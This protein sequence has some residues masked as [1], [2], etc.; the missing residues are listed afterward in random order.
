MSGS[1]T[2]SSMSAPVVP[3]GS[4]PSALP[5]YGIPPPGFIPPTPGIPPPFGV[6]MPS[7][8]PPSVFGVPPF[9][10]SAVPPSGFF[11]QTMPAQ[12]SIENEN[13]RTWTEHKSPDG[14]TYYYNNLTKQ[15]LWDKPDELK[16]A[17][18]IMLSQCPWKEYKTEDGK[19]YYHNVSTKESSWTIPPELGELKSKIATEE[20]NKTTIANGQTGTD[21][22]SSTVQISTAAM[23]VSQSVVTDSL[24]TPTR[25]PISALDQAMAATLAAITV[26]SP[27]TEDSM[28]AKPSPSSDSRTSTPEPKTTFKDKRE[29]LEAFKELLREK[30]V[31]SNAS[32][33]QALKYIQR[34]PRLA[35]LGKLTERKQAFHAYKT[36]KQKEEKEEQR[37][38][39]KKAK[40]DLEAFLLV[41][42]SISS[43]TKYFRCEEIY[44]N[45]EVWKNVPEGERRDIYEDA[46]FHLS[47]REKEE[48]KALRK[49]NMKNLTRVLDSITDITHRTAWTEAQQL[50][51][52]NP[53][54][55][56]DNDLLA[57]DKEDALV[58]FEQ[59]IRELEHEEEE[60]RERGKRR[61]KRLQ[62]KNRDSF[63]NLL[64][65]LHENGKLTSMS[66]WVEL[67]PIISTDLR[68]SAMLG[69]P[70]S[71]PLDLFK[72]YIEDLKSRFHDEK[73][74]IKEILKQKSFEV[75][76]KTTFEDFA[77]VVCEDKRSVILDGGNVKLTY[78]AL[79]EK[80]EVREKERLKEENRRSKKL[81]S[82]FRNLL[83]AKELDHLVSW[84]DSVSK[85]E[86]DPAFDAIT[87]ES[88]RIRIFKEYQRDM[89][90]TCGHHHSRSKKNKKKEKKQK[91]RS[92]SSRSPSTTRSGSRSKSRSKSPSRSKSD[93]NE[94]K[95]VDEELP[96]THKKSKKKK[97]KKKKERSRSPSSDSE[98]NRTKE[99]KKDKE[100]KSRNDSGNDKKNKEDGEWSEDELE[101]RRRLLLEQL[102]EEHQ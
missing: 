59:H 38:K 21:I 69:Q 32:W 7:M 44:G 64:D 57:M 10:A 67:Y 65:E 2:S 8:A 45:L 97:S 66:L 73:K 77:T 41:D 88:D 5:P 58:V 84:E 72:F 34:D 17:A 101:R 80:A 85:L 93:E 1:G 30:N 15:S 99:K 11:P 89:E 83:R 18:E 43:T 27:Q 98:E 51:L 102:A 76:I 79:L 36:Q 94:A 95:L 13:K 48:E 78:N 55:A 92:S 56:E 60:E 62:R 87:E 16:T 46:I 26:P 49:R 19:I 100:K 71:N 96:S 22:L 40:E 74:I 75:D 91:R 6:A 70:G 14:R 90:E 86:G 9:G 37:L 82:A 12:G 20:S 39:A 23:T 63:L 52:D 81:E 4:F 42:S 50:L 68:F 35:A 25:A 47:K 29:A 3:S 33:D 53:S 24:P 54:F 61:I 28:D 31:P